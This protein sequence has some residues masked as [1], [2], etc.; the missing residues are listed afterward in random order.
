MTSK[1]PDDQPEV[2]AMMLEAQAAGSRMRQEHRFA[3][4]LLDR[5]ATAI[6]IV[7]PDRARAMNFGRYLA[8]DESEKERAI[9]FA[10]DL[11]IAEVMLAK[12]QIDVVVADETFRER[13]ARLIGDEK[14]VVTLN[15][16]DVFA[17]AA[18]RAAC[19]HAEKLRTK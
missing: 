3:R 14:R 19:T 9:L 7:S 4:A 16:N 6:L 15:G 12:K 18:V 1:R 5:T 10:A 2:E 13:V 11:G 8:E 17:K